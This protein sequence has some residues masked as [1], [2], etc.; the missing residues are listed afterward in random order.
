M[1]SKRTHDPEATCV[2]RIPGA[3]KSRSARGSMLRLSHDEPQRLEAVAAKKGFR[4]LTIHRMQELIR[5]HK[6]E[7]PTSKMLEKD[8]ALL[9]IKHVLHMESDEDHLIYVQFRSLRTTSP[10]CTVV[11]DEN[12]AKLKEVN[13]AEDE[14]VEKFEK[15]VAKKG[16]AQNDAAHN[17]RIR[18]L[19]A[20]RARVP[21]VGYTPKAIPDKDLA[22][23][24]GR[25]LLPVRPFPP[26]PV[27]S[28]DKD[29]AWKVKTPY[30]EATPKSRTSTFH[31]WHNNHPHLLVCLRFA[32][33][34]ETE[35]D[36]DVVC[37]YDLSGPQP[38]DA[39]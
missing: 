14:T 25:A 3:G 13:A 32:W 28:L 20:S 2:G 10:F 36:R 1:L 24:E 27:L 17:E 35:L 38:E 39:S 12:L 31:E 30:R 7:V 23:A 8:W 37:P 34:V 29:V 21:G 4:H 5:I 9:L 19:G 11:T 26:Q 33:D 22:L 18:N 16:L 6:L 15:S